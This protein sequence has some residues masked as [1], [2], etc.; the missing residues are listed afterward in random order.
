MLEGQDMAQHL[1]QFHEL[2]NQLRGLSTGGKE[3]DD[4]EL[5]TILT[6]SLPECYEPLIMA[7]Q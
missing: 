5:L 7:L 4:S 3:V 6:L 2:A 1:N